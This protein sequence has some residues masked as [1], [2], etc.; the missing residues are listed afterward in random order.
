M[1][2]SGFF[3]SVSLGSDSAYGRA[4]RTGYVETFPLPLRKICMGRYPLYLYFSENNWIMT[5]V[6][7]S[8]SHSPCGSPAGWTGNPFISF[9]DWIFRY[10]YYV[11]FIMRPY[12]MGGLNSLYYVWK[13]R[14][15]IYIKIYALLSLV[16]IMSVCPSHIKWSYERKNWCRKLKLGVSVPCGLENGCN[17]FSS[18]LAIAK[19]RNN[20]ERAWKK[21]RASTTDITNVL[22]RTNKCDSAVQY[23]I[24]RQ[25]DT[26]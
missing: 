5:R 10:L 1:N 11:H 22:A 2:P 3:T 6:Y 14:R 21:F 20:G 24:Y 18:A 9:D 19:E 26:S 12:L 8:C 7:R 13:A 15:I 16:L 17:L 4:I 25:S 23:Y